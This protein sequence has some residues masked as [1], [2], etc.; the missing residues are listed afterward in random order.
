M[1]FEHSFKHYPK[2]SIGR[3]PKLTRR[4]NDRALKQNCTCFP[5]ITNYKEGSLTGGYVTETQELYTDWLPLGSIH[6]N[7]CGSFKHKS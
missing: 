6:V 3:F 2:T 4:L 5:A 7:S 1:S